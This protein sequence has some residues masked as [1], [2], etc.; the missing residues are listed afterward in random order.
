MERAVFGKTTNRQ[1]RKQQ[2]MRITAFIV[3][4]SVIVL[5]ILWW[6]GVNFISTDGSDNI[7]IN[8][9]FPAGGYAVSPAR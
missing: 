9:S 5:N 2:E 4:L 7:T 3:I 1:L 6:T 8:T